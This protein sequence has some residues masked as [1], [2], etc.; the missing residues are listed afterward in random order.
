MDISSLEHVTLDTPLSPFR[1]ARYP[2][3]KFQLE[4]LVYSLWVNVIILDKYAPGCPSLLLQRSAYDSHPGCWE[5]PGGKVDYDDQNLRKA[6]ERV[7]KERTGRTELQILDTVLSKIERKH[8][9][10]SF[11]F[12]VVV[13]RQSGCMGSAEEEN[14][15]LKW[16]TKDDVLRMDRAAFYGTELETILGAFDTVEKVVDLSLHGSSSTPRRIQHQ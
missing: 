9:W 14:R 1:I 5:L 15:D 10:H 7:A 8:H 3:H 13:D 16:V 6:A 11:T 4:G 12:L 2:G